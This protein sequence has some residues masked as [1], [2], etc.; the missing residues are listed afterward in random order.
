MAQPLEDMSWAQLSE[1][2]IQARDAVLECMDAMDTLHRNLS[3]E[4]RRQANPMGIALLRPLP[5]AHSP[6]DS[7]DMQPSDQGFMAMMSAYRST[8]GIARG[9]ELMGLMSRRLDAPLPSL[10]QLIAGGNISGFKWNRTC[11][12]PVFQFNLADCSIKNG[13]TQVIT[14]LNQAFDGWGLA[15]WFAQPNCWLDGQQ[16]AALI[17]SDLSAVLQAARAD[18]FAVLG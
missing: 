13:V 14:E 2:F 16:P 18:R 5:V 1:A 17:D 11:W 15:A 7:I 8:G 9:G 12:A 6:N 10:E 3:S 4:G